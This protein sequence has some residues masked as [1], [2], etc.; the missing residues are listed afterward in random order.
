MAQLRQQQADSMGVKMIKPWDKSIEIYPSV[1]LQ[2]YQNVEEWLDKSREVFA[3]ISPVLVK[4]FDLQRSE[5][6]MD[7]ES[8]P[9]KS[10]WNYA[11]ILPASS[12]TFIFINGR[13]GNADLFMLFHEFGH[14]VHQIEMSEIAYMR[15]RMLPEEMGE[16][17]STTMELLACEHLDI[18]YPQEQAEVV[19]HN[20]L[21][22]MILRWPFVA[23]IALFQHWA[24]TNPEQGAN[25]VV[26][27]EYWRSLHER[28][29]PGIDYT[30]FKDDVYMEWREF[31]Q[32]FVFPFYAIEYAF[33][34]VGAV[35]IW[36]NYRT[37]PR[38]AMEQWLQALK[39][40]HTINVPEFYKLAGAKFAVDAQVLQNVVDEL[41]GALLS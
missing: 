41:K 32:V 5:G 22:S 16:V 39:R 31:M 30:G 19:R 36:Q 33:A 26:C 1:H 15:Q 38:G 27:D 18:F 7:L 11:E 10:P 29:M 25:P 20:H 21:L 28:F 24:Y 9:N 8:R 4:H 40:G 6:L 17:A 3:R 13:G 34:Q 14:A 37:D 23:M 12:R 35:Q 2:P